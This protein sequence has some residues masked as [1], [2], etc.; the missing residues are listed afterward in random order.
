MKSLLQASLV[1][2]LLLLPLTTVLGAEQTLHF[3]IDGMYCAVCPVVIS[4]S[5]RKLKGVKDVSVSMK[6][7]SAVVVTDTSTRAEDIIAQ[8]LQTGHK[9]GGTYTATLIT[10]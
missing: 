7:S 10:E 3:K 5:I 8:V 4:K 2:G 6:E 1:V 9:L